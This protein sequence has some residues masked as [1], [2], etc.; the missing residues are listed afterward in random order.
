MPWARGSASVIGHTDGRFD[1][2]QKRGKHITKHL[3]LQF[4]KTSG[5]LSVGRD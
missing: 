2:P 4:L 3:C 5:D 1:D